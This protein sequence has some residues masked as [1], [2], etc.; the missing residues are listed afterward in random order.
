MDGLMRRW[1]GGW[2]NVWVDGQM[3]GW[4]SRNVRVDGGW[5]EDGQMSGK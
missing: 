1:M 5:I 3:D 2:V 4:V